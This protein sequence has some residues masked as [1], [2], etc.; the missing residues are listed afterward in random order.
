MKIRILFFLLFFV[1][2]T[3]AQI[4]EVLELDGLQNLNTEIQFKFGDRIF[5]ETG[6]PN[7]LWVTDGTAIGTKKIKGGSNISNYYLI[8]D[9]CF[10]TSSN[11]LFEINADSYVLEV[12]ATASGVIKNILPFKDEI[13]V[14][15]T[16]T[17]QSP[18]SFL[19]RV[20]PDNGN[21]ELVFQ[22]T[23]R[24]DAVVGFNGGF[25]FNDDTSL[26]YS[27]GTANG[28][29][30]ILEDTTGEIQEINLLAGTSLNNQY[31][32]RLFTKTYGS[33]PWITDGSIG[34][35][36]LLKD[37]YPGKNENDFSFSAFPT[38][39]FQQ[40]NEA[41]FFAYAEGFELTLFKT[42]GTNE[43]TEALFSVEETFDIFQIYE[44]F[45]FQ[46][47]VYFVANSASTGFEL[48]KTDGTLVGTRLVKDI[49][50]GAGNSASSR[51][52]RSIK[53]TEDYIYFNANDGVFGFELWRTDGTAT[54]T[55]L[56]SDFSPGPDWSFMIPLAELGD[57]FYFMEGDRDRG[58]R[59]YSFKQSN[60][61]PEIP[62]YSKNYDWFESI[63]YSYQISSN[64][65]FLYNDEM[66]VDQEDNVYLIGEFKRS[67]LHF[68]GSENFIRSAPTEEGPF[69][70]FIASYNDKGQFRWAKEIG[71]NRP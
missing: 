5:F 30:T 52:R 54:G 32:F 55:T 29:M 58:Y 47:E 51:V 46:D 61:L 12:V 27:D 63:G 17:I 14:L 6:N 53:L 70:N 4:E 21:V 33:E 56:I 38:N 37:I 68:Y 45:V 24:V 8:G 13:I 28:T 1:S 35:T 22:T 25:L 18:S 59:L 19:Q 15:S 20:N 69:R 31:V 39:F 66:E 71:G 26:L 57:S 67:R 23:S 7:D 49:W 9:R 65:P 16:L 43:G 40:N 10:L 3:Y 60:P 48:W 11:I 44:L 34:G 41:Y 2:T 50:K 42:N 36:K 62:T 64:I